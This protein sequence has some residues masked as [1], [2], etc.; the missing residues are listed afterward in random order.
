[1]HCNMIY[2]I[3]DLFVYF[4][5]L[6]QS[7]KIDNTGDHSTILITIVLFCL[8]STGLK[9]CFSYLNKNVPLKL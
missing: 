7:S 5:Y 9:S 3:N 2:A 6:P 8:S 1:M 4:I